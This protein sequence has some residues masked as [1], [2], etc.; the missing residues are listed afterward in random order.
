MRLREKVAFG[1]E[2]KVLRRRGIMGFLALPDHFSNQHKKQKNSRFAFFVSNPTVTLECC[3]ARFSSM[4][5][6]RWDFIKRSAF[7]GSKKS[8]V[9]RYYYRSSPESKRRVLYIVRQNEGKKS[10][11]WRTWWFCTQTAVRRRGAVAAWEL[12]FLQFVSIFVS[13]SYINLVW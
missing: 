2:G 12:I 3:R 6:G 13:S 9:S 5:W 10:S 8:N 11:R 1:K 7:I 4:H